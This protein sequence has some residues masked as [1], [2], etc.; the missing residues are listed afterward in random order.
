[1]DEGHLLPPESLAAS[2][3]VP[4]EAGDVAGEVFPI[5]HHLHPEGDPDLAHLRS[6]AVAATAIDRRVHP[7]EADTAMMIATED[8]LRLIAITLP[9]V[10]TIRHP[11]AGGLRR[12]TTATGGLIDQVLLRDVAMVAV[13]T[14]VLQESAFLSATFLP[15]SLPKTCIR[16]LAV[17]GNYGT[18]TF[19]AT[20][21]RSNPRVSRSLNTPLPKWRRKPAMR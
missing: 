10:A 17:L 8:R 11:A 3:R 14:K 6:A 19:L 18:S 21:I 4:V 12:S 13:A 9:S 2:D 1:M 5:P 20:I 16:R 7:T 15:T